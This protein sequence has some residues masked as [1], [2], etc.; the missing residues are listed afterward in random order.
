MRG[1]KGGEDLGGK[2]IQSPRREGVSEEKTRF[3]DKVIIDTLM[4]QPKVEE[5]GL[6]FRSLLELGLGASV[7]YG[8]V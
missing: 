1:M 8:R 3:D 5:Q 2:R 7:D 4:R 6:C